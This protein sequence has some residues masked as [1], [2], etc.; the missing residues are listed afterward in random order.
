MEI[1]SIIEQINKWNIK[2]NREKQYKVI[3][4]IGD[5]GLP[6][7]TVNLQIPR[8]GSI[9]G[10][11]QIAN[12]TYVLAIKEPKNKME[13]VAELLA[14]GCEFETVR[15]PWVLAPTL[16]I[17][18]GSVVA[19]YSIKPGMIIGKYVTLVDSM[20]TSHSVGDYSTVLYFSNVTG[21]VGE[22][23]YVGSH[24]YTH[25]GKVVGDNCYVADGS[26]VVKDIKPGNSVSGVPARRIKNT[27]Y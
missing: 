6:F 4:Y 23:S 7:N 26:I 2:Y 18:E 12:E 19:A 27:A 8:L 3:G 11:K 1:Y 13:T 9:H 5:I 20:L 14:G 15:A 24:V 25:L 17:G 21:N 10:W 22:R 16:Q